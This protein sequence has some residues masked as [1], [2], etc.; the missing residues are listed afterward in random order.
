MFRKLIFGLSVA[1]ISIVSC[2]NEDDAPM[3][4]IFETDMGNDIDDALALDMLYKYMDQ[5]IVDVLAIGLNKTGFGPVEYVGLMN[6]WY[7]Y[8]DIPIGK[9]T[10]GIDYNYPESNFAAKVSAMKDDS[11]NPLF[12]TCFNSKDN[13][14]ETPELYRKVLAG[15]PDGSVTLISVGYS[16]NLVRLMESCPDE[17]SDLS[18]MEL[19]ARKVKLLS[20]MAG[21]FRPGASAEFNVVRDIPSAKM[22]FEKWPTP[23]VAS[24]FDVGISICYPASSIEND[25]NWAEP[26]PLVEGYK[27]WGAMPYDRPTW[28]LTSVLYA[29]EGDAWFSVSPYGKI[30]VEDDG[31]T[32]FIPCS[33]GDRR[34][35]S[36][37]KQQ[38]DAILARFLD[39]IPTK[40]S[41]QSASNTR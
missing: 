15:V 23:L 34:Y 26:H 9:I 2:V 31:C 11:G 40:P 37:N 35:L 3:K 29:V 6:Q 20:V 18:G 10:E 14:L 7:G 38:A 4:V 33:D 24:P 22:I 32:K 16:T 41:G 28:D 13:L 17:Y 30:K 25:F 21:D 36:V 12:K 1:L 5:G 39:I 19:I 27:A 8:P